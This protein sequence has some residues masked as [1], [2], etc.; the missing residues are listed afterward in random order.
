VLIETLDILVYFFCIVGIP[1]IIIYLKE[2]KSGLNSE[3]KNLKYFI[4]KFFWI[5]FTFKERINR[6]E[7]IIYGGWLFLGSLLLI[8]GLGVLIFSSI[9]KDFPILGLPLFV[10]AWSF[11]FHQYAVYIKRLHDLNKSG[12][13]VLWAIVPILGYIYLAIICFFNKGTEGLNDYGSDPND[14]YQ[15]KI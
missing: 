8:V 2:K 6:Y 10:L 14:N 12:W 13:N 3:N 7:F 1:I 4:K 5:N 11:I 15:K 9:H